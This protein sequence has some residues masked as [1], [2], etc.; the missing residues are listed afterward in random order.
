[1][2]SIKVIRSDIQNGRTYGPEA[3]YGFELKT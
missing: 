1:M 2:I 3:L